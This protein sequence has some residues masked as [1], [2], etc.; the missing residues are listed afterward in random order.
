MGNY[1]GWRKVRDKFTK[2]DFFER[3]EFERAYKRKEIEKYKKDNWLYL[4]IPFFINLSV[5]SL[6]LIFWV[7]VI[8]NVS[9]DGDS[10]FGFLI[11]FFGS[12][13]FAYQGVQFFLGSWYE[14]EFSEFAIEYKAFKKWKENKKYDNN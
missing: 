2:E 3:C 12:F 5:I 8:P 7:W 14:S 10:A 1:K 6:V 9:I 13:V 4:L 11:T